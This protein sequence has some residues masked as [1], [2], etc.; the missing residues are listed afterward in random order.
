MYCNKDLVKQGACL[1][2]IA[3]LKN[4]L[5]QALHPYTGKPLFKKV[6]SFQEAYGDINKLPV[7]PDLIL[8]PNDTFSVGNAIPGAEEL[9]LR[10]RYSG[11]HREEGVLLINGDSV[12]Q[13]VSKSELNL[14][15]IAPT[16]LCLHDIDIPCDVDGQV[17]K[18]A[19][20]KS[21]DV[22]FS[23]QNSQKEPKPQFYRD[24]EEGLIAEK[25]R[26]LGYLQ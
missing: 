1:E 21:L 13:D 17:I 16:L 9:L 4:R 5:M 18:E 22:R 3:E 26:S 25:L 15:D 14:I 12:K 19:F 6:I 23:K 10:A 24:S 11:I 8:I 2:L 7:A 20:T